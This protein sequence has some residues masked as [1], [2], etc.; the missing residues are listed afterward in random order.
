MRAAQPGDAERA[1]IVTTKLGRLEGEV[2]DGVTVFR[3]VPYAAPPMGELR[4]RAP[5]P[6]RP[7]PGVRDARQFGP[8]PPQLQSIMRDLAPQDEDC[9]HLNVWAPSGATR[10]RGPLPVLVF[11]HGG[12]F[13]SGACTH[14]MYDCRELARRAGMI[15]VSFNYRIGALGFVDLGAL[16]ESGFAADA[17][18]GVRD[19]IAALCWVREHIAEF[20]GHPERVTLFGQSAGAMCIAALLTS[21]AAAGLFTRAIAQS[22]AG[23]HVTT[24]A[25][26]A[27]IARHM[28][29]ALGLG[30]RDLSRLRSLPVAAIVRAQAACLRHTIEV[31]AAGRPLHNANMTLLPVVDGELI[32]Q[33]PIDAARAG[34]GAELPLLLGT[35]RDEW[36]FWVF[37]TDVSKRDLDDDG[38]LQVIERFVPGR[39]A[40]ACEV[41]RARLARE[42]GERPAPWRIYCAFE[43]DRIFTLPAVR[44]AE[45]RAGAAAPT[46]MYRFDWSGPL[47]EGQLGSCH[48]M[49]VPFVLGLTDEGFG[50]V[51]AG[52]GEAAR[53]LSQ[54]VMAAWIAFARGGD[55]SCAAVGDW[56]GFASE[57]R[58]TML[59]ARE[60][61]VVT[62]PDS[63]TLEFWSDLI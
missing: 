55:P 1:V 24:R 18:N 50:Q 62:A 56:P 51:F 31:G 40:A 37:L 21:P 11:V 44:L 7:W 5:E 43:T 25:H 54:R 52:G 34:A 16:G 48:T 17:N 8:T 23:H 42:L 26:S 63:A 32:A 47:F 58:R 60:P 29:D 39:A 2:L 46:F 15:V 20:G 36:N 45:A 3:G 28:L 6:P 38:L 4:F 41:Y 10:P 9:L 13:V 12:A 30:P 22:G 59:L 19:Q 49:E 14:P 35:N 57:Q 61:A 27:V 53:A 33:V